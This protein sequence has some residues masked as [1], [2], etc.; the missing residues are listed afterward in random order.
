MSNLEKQNII[1]SENLSEQHYFQ[2]LLL[3]AEKLKLLTNEEIESIKLQSMQL[4]AN[5]IELFTGG[6]S[7]SVKVETA[8]SIMLS[9]FYCIGIFLKSFSDTDICISEIKHRPLS[10]MYK[11]GR[12]LTENYINRAKDLLKAVKLSRIDTGNQAYNDTID[13]GISSFFSD[14]NADFSA[15]DTQASIDYPLGNDKM[16][17]SGVE[18]INDYLGKLLLENEFCKK[19]TSRD[20]YRVMK[21]YSPDFEDLLVNIFQ[22]VLINALG[23]ILLNKDSLKLNFE[24]SDIKKLQEKLEI[25]SEEQLYLQLKQASQKLFEQLNII[26]TEL[27]K[28]ILL[29][30]KDISK[31]LK[32]ALENKQLNSVFVSFE[33]DSVKQIMQFEDGHKMDD[34]LFRRV[35]DE[36]RQC[37]YVSD[38]IAIIKESI[39]SIIDL[40]DIF[41]T[42]C[43]FDEEYNKVFDSLGNTEI[44]IL[45]K[46][47]HFDQYNFKFDDIEIEKQW[48]G[49][50]VNYLSG[51]NSHRREY[52]NNL[53]NGLNLEMEKQNENSQ[54]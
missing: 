15:H 13:E 27:Q 26:N 10:Y 47:M 6:N 46:M 50:L 2:S 24:A 42:A 32:N 44:A 28:Y 1:K 21:G 54:N 48:Q 5:Q 43:L 37:R 7:S 35:S 19:F 11:E 18:Y 51:M 33:E 31:S 30:L 22:M 45:I 53:C 20:I 34:E 49:M 36:I 52:I 38:K 12:K 23:C 4:L 17:L 8:Q 39:H 16:N 14:Y 3:Y 9:I 40:K 29:N 25:L 41:E